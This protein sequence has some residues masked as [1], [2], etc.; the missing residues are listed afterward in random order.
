M[1]SVV[2]SKIGLRTRRSEV[3]ISQGAH[4]LFKCSLR[5]LQ[6]T[7]VR[8]TKFRCRMLQLLCRGSA[9]RAWPSKTTPVSSLNIPVLQRNG[10]AAGTHDRVRRVHHYRRGEPS[11]RESGFHVYGTSRPEGRV[12]L[13][14]V[15]FSSTHSAASLPANGLPAAPR[16]FC[17]A[18]C[19]LSQ[20]LCDLIRPN[21]L[22][23]HSIR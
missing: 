15:S 12:T 20:M 4:H 16:Q 23:S 6:A 5:S 3:R 11:G 13:I 17:A 8:R 7:Y 14:P 2:E 9:S 10:G 18:R 19:C 1:H 22:C 21:Y